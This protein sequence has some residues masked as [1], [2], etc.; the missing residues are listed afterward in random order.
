MGLDCS[1]NAFHGAYSSFGRWRKMLAIVTGGSYPPHDD[2]SLDNSQ[3]YYDNE[4][5]DWVK[6]KGFAELMKHS[7]CDGKINYDVCKLLADDLTGLLP[8]IIDYEKTNGDGGGHL[9]LAGGYTAVTI[10]F[11]NGC[12]QAQKEKK[13]LTFD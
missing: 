1:H 13:P 5:Y 6:H 4:I 10:Q 11:I 7:D 2:K 8:V 3:I 12:K 9:T